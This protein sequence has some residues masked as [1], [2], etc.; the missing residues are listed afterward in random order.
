MQTNLKVRAMSRVNVIAME[1]VMGQIDRSPTDYIMPP[2][3]LSERLTAVANGEAGE[4]G[5]EPTASLMA[6]RFAPEAA[7]NDAIPVSDA[8]QVEPLRARARSAAELD[9]AEPRRFATP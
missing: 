2:R 5:E 3:K 8:P 6:Q 4:T 1:G 9:P 7:A